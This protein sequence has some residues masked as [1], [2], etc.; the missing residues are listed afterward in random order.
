MTVEP[1][2]LSPVGTELLDDPG[3]DPGAVAESLRNIARSNRWFGG[4]A[5]VLHGLSRVLAGVPAR[6]PAHA[7]RPGHRCRRP[8]AR[9]R[10]PGRAEGHPAAC[11]S[12]SSAAGSPR[13]WRARFG[14]PLR[15]G[16]AGAP[17][18]RAQVGG[19][20]AGE[21]GGP[22][23]R[24]RLR[25]PSARGPATGWPGAAS[26][27]PIS[28]AAG[29]LALAFWV[30]ARVLRFDPLHAVRRPDLDPAGIHRRRAA[31]PARVGRHHGKVSRR[32]GYRLVATWSPGR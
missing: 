5:A 9:R 2:T 20:R 13:R 22:P 28:G 10:A 18:F 19:R 29:W 3:A 32:P 23:P 15:G 6:H 7:A 17:P 30:G 4:T 25:H 11:R 21:P 1:L 27:C 12:G 31:R 14:H 16:C 24:R 26:S 8:P